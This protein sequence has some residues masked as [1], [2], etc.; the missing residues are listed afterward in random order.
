MTGSLVG[1]IY[2][3]CLVLGLV[4]SAVLWPLVSGGMAA[5]YALGTATGAGSLLLVETSVRVVLRPR[6]WGARSHRAVGT[7][8]LCRYLLLGVLIAWLVATPSLSPGG[9]ALGVTVLP[10]AILYQGIVGFVREQAE[11]AHLRR[12]GRADGP[13][14]KEA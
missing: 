2:R 12:G 1:R 3:T 6:G 9:F 5:A 13:A 4:G 10:V 7:L 14:S 11:V 8:A